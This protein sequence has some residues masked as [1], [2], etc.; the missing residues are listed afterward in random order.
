MRAA[1]RDP[2]KEILLLAEQATRGDPLTR[3]E[4]AEVLHDALL[5]ISSGYDFAVSSAE[6]SAQRERE[7]YVVLFSATKFKKGNDLPFKIAKETE[8]TVFFG[9]FL[10][11]SGWQDAVKTYTTRS[12]KKRTTRRARP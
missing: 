5:E 2:R 10:N 6:R 3:K 7:R 11:V 8:L 1:R 12:P 4:I 9:G